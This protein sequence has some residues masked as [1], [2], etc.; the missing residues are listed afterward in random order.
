MSTNQNS[1][2]PR[3]PTAAKHQQDHGPKERFQRMHN[4]GD[5]HPAWRFGLENGRGFEE[6][7]IDIGKIVPCWKHLETLHNLDRLE[8]NS[9]TPTP[10]PSQTLH[11]SPHGCHGCFVLKAITKRKMRIKR[12]ALTIRVIRIIRKACGEPVIWGVSSMG[13]STPSYSHQWGN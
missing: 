6:V 13:D 2:Q 12:T 10:K 7:H 11:P 8:K 4:R 9:H 1:I 3:T 5:E